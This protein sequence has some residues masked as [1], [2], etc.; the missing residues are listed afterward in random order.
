VITHN[1]RA[2]NA[3]AFID[4][5]KIRSLIL[6]LNSGNADMVFMTVTAIKHCLESTGHDFTDLALAL[7]Q[8]PPSF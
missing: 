7:R 2:R 4:L 5:P 1:R 3:Q 8:E 6:L